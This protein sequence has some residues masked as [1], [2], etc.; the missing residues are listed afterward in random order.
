MKNRKLLLVVIT[1]SLLLSGCAFG[2]EVDTTTISIN[3]KGVVTETI[4]EDF[5]KDYYNADELE[6]E[7][8]QAVADYNKTAGSENVGLNSFEYMEESQQVKAELQYASA[9]DYEQMNERTLF[10]GTVQEAYEAGYEM[11]SMIN[12]EDGSTVSATDVLELGDKH[13]VIS[14][15]TLNIRVSGKITYASEGVVITDNKTAT[16]TDDGET[17]SYIIYE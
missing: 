17:L 11:I 1:V 6:Q 3:K 9:D 5:D 13:I 2:T 16:L 12:Q 15:E 7:I 10:C 4:I 14:E 8:T